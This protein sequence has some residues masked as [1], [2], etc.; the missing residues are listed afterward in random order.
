MSAHAI[1][2]RITQHV[3]SAIQRTDIPENGRLF[4][5]VEPEAVRELCRYVFRD[6]DARYVV[7]IGL[8]DRAA[9]GGYLVAHDFAFDREHVLC[10]ILTAL[11]GT[12][13]RVDS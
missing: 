10:S 2:A 4:L 6:L 1:L 13:P 11:P 7:S 5:Y 3:P 8:D 9:S 12:S